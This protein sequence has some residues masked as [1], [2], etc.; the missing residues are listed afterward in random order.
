LTRQ[1]DEWFDTACV[2]F[3]CLVSKVEEKV[4]CRDAWYRADYRPIMRRR[5]QLEIAIDFVELS[6]SWCYFAESTLAKV[7][8]FVIR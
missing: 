8:A 7:P 4:L 2:T 1:H 3:K 5:L 6:P